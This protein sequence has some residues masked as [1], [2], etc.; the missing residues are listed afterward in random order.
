MRILLVIH[1]YPPYYMAGSEV[2]TYNLARE[3]AKTNDVFVFHR[4]EDKDIPLHQFFD[5][6]EEGVHIRKINNYEPTPATFYDKYLNPEIDDAFR[7][8]V[9]KVNPDV[10][11][12]GHL[13]HLSTQI[14]I[15]AKR[16]FGLP[17]L[18][19]IHDFWMFCHRGQLINP[20]NWEICPLPN[21]AQCTKCAAFHYQ[22]DDFEPRLIEERDEHIRQTLD[23]IDVFFAPSHTLEHF[24][25]N[26]GVDSRKIVYAKYGFNVSKLAKHPKELHPE[27]TFGFTGRIIHTKGVHLLCEAFNNVEGNA[28]LLIYG[29]Y[30]SDYGKR[31]KEQYSSDRIQFKGPYHNNELQSVLDSLDVLVC[32]SIWL[33]N[34]PL[35]IQEAQSVELPVLVSDR[36]GMAELVHDGVDGFTFKL[37]DAEDLRNR[38][39][40]LVNHPEKLLNLVKPIEKVVS[41]EDDAALCMQ[42]YSEI[43]K[44]NI[45]YPHRPCPQ[46]M[47]FITNPDKCNLHCKMCDTFS[48]ANRHRL[49]ESPR[50]DLDFNVVKDTIE[51][52]V[53]HGLKEI[54]PSTMGEPLL[55]PHF[56]ELVGLCKDLHVK[57][58]L[59]TNGTFPGKGIEH[60]GPK[61]V[62]I[63]SDVKFSL[64]GINPEIN[65]NIMCGANTQKQ[66]HNIERFIQMRDETGS[67][68]TVTLQCTFMKSNLDEL[69]NIIAWAIEHGVNRVK[70]HHLWKTSDALDCEMLR[71]PENAALWNQACEECHK[72]AGDKVKLVNFDPVDLTK[73]ALNNDNTFCQFL[74]KELWVEYDGSYQICCCPS[75]VRKAF[76]DFRN[77][78]DQSPLT[79][80]NG[81][82]YCDFINNWGD[83]ENCKKCNMRCE[84]KGE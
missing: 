47:T 60:W 65:E 18:F 48:E 41:I 61:L 22:K 6:F 23:C 10:V 53:H 51:R 31:L 71:T 8:Y 76:G 81:K 9:K 5:S 59:T 73:P 36:G 30:E 21:A 7:E 15:I 11:H 20:Q 57:M 38:M 12:I 83:S 14:P 50:P 35:V 79:M 58:N 64:N 2:Y 39:Q 24:Y 27:I 13:S 43:K 49:K 70:G 62:N 29:D 17:V 69:K 54:I 26:M 40:D 34:A 1:G 52:L 45:V 42:K 80:W 44:Q 75:E 56:E 33:E 84:R 77:V 37:G 46:R 19:T 32:P 3:L 25:I 66:L 74:G 82:H 4:I 78:K 72:I 67:K 55:Y 63:I 28:K 16:E 68:A